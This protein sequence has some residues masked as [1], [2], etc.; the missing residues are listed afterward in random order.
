M[1]YYFKTT[2][3]PVGDL[4]LVASDKGLTAIL[5]QDDRANRVPLEEMHEDQNHVVLNETA[6][7]LQEY[8]SGAR[9]SFSLPLDFRGTDFQKKVWGALLTIPFGESHSR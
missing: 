8:F 6:R 7:Q 2:P 1:S 9:K 3:S 4:T 5:W